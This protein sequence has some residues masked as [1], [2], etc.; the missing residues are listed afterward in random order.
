MDSALLKVL[1][2]G[3]GLGI[4][5][6]RQ[7]PCVEGLSLMGPTSAARPIRVRNE[8]SFHEDHEY[9]AKPIFRDF[10]VPVPEGYPAFP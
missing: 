8:G 9:Q 7:W 1:E 3:S 5:D 4:A 2:P 6:G 10:G